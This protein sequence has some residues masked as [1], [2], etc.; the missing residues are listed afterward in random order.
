M[1][2]PA[3][4]SVCSVTTLLLVVAAVTP[5]STLL[6]LIWIIYYWVLYFML[7]HEHSQWQFETWDMV[8]GEAARVQLNSVMTWSYWYG[9][10][11]YMGIVVDFVIF[12]R[13]ARYMRIH[14]GLKAFYQ[15]R[16]SRAQ[17][18]QCMCVAALL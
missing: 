4:S 2:H 5:C 3:A 9:A 12:L 6:T 10:W 13:I 11:L 18:P 14:K 7:L 1:L 8:N 16:A 17:L 15:V